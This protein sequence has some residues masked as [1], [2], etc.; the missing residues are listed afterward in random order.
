LIPGGF[1]GFLAGNGVV[2]LRM[3]RWISFRRYGDGDN[4]GEFENEGFVGEKIQSGK[5]LT[6]WQK[7]YNVAKAIFQDRKLAVAYF[8]LRSGYRHGLVIL[9]IVSCVYRKNI[10]CAIESQLGEDL[11]WIG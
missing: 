1:A 8:R 6:I 2:F 5:N 4:A 3:V 11:N 10:L 9:N 7:L